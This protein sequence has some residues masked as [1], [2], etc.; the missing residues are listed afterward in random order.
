MVFVQATDLRARNAL[1]FGVLIA[2]AIAV[3]FFFFSE[4]DL[5]VSR[6]FYV[7]GLG[8]KTPGFYLA[9]YSAL[10]FF[11]WLVDAISRAVLLGA[12][13]ITFILI[14][15]KHTKLLASIM[16]TLSLILGPTVVV[17][18]VFKDHWDRA[19]PRQIVDFGGNKQFTPA[20]V[21]SD[22]CDRNCSFPSGHAAAG[23]S[24]LV[25]YFVSGMRIWIWTG[26][27]FGGLTGLTRIMVGAHFLS[28]IVF[29]F[30]I[31]YVVS[32]VVI[33]IIAQL[34]KKKLSQLTV[35]DK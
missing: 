34:A 6:L 33:W 22:Q 18:S 11:F 15:K 3:Y 14:L 23:F 9:D 13:V 7:E 2:G 28:D 27:V 35:T 24:F 8:Q 16:V 30:F 31:V 10:Q 4:I 19:R 12:L 17:N 26:L 25:G 21:L 1:K 5:A 32:A 29:A 20:W